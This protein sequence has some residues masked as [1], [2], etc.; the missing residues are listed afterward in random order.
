MNG[1]GNENRTR[2]TTVTGW[3]INRYTIP[4]NPNEVIQQY[5]LAISNNSDEIVVISIGM[6]IVRKKETKVWFGCPVKDGFWMKTIPTLSSE[7]CQ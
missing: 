2:D 5:G 3:R 4:R 1:Q 7:P 6:L